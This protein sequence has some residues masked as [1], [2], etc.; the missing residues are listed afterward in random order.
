MLVLGR[1]I[2]A[3]GAGCALDAGA[4]D[5]A[6]RLPRRAAGQGDR[7]SHHVRH[8]WADGLAV[9]RRRADRHVRLAQ[10]VRLCA[11]GRRRDRAHC[12]S[13]DVRDPSA[14]QSH[15]GRRERRC[16][17]T[18]ALF[19]RLRFNAFV[20]QSG[21][22][23]GAFMVMASAVGLADD[24]AAAP[25]GHR[26]R[27]LLHA[28]SDRLLHRQFHLDPA[29]Q[30]RLDRDDGAGRIA[31]GDG[32][33]DRAGGRAVLR[34]ASR[35]SRSSFRASSSPWRRASR[36]PTP[37]SAP[38]RRSRALPAPRPASACSCRTSAPRCSRQ[39]YGLLADG[40]PRPMIMIALLCGVLTLVTGAVPFL[41]KRSAAAAG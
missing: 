28:V 13:G 36:C 32:D 15:Q 40:T 35:R 17:A 29:R 4:R 38:W 24:R 9:H 2:Q 23:T 6:R 19:R 41:L 34:R 5:R 30:P 10:R 31:A 12:L 26:V 18:C 39:L 20:L 14:G 1:L 37:R 3:I 21:F 22:N 11:A 8:A 27:A 33:R 25:A 7:L 16:R